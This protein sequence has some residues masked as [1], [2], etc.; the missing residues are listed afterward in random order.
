MVTGF[1]LGIA[2]SAY[3]VAIED[4]APTMTYT[5]GSVKNYTQDAGQDLLFLNKKSQSSNY[6][7]GHIDELRISDTAR[8]TSGYGTLPP[9]SASSSD[10][11]T[12]LLLHFDGTDGST[13]ITDS[14]SVG[15]TVTANGDFE[16]DTAIKKFGTA[17]GLNGQSSAGSFSVDDLDDPDLSGDFTIE[18]WVRP[19]GLGGFQ[20]IL[21]TRRASGDVLA[22]EILFDFNGTGLRL[23]I[24]GSDRSSDTASDDN[25]YWFC[26]QRE[27]TEFSWWWIQDN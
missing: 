12:T 15:A 19:S 26:L 22:D 13:T 6:W 2:G 5:A 4:T 17:A 3:V 18:A 14:S 24:D 9:T 20:A 8:Y 27:G 11:D 16:L 1:T 10:A 21:D 7:R 23:F 25:W